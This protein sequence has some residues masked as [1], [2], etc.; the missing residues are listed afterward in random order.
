[1][2]S[3]PVHTGA[4]S[5]QLALAMAHS[6]ALRVDGVLPSAPATTTA[7]DTKIAPQPGAEPPQQ[8]A[9]S[10]LRTGVLKAQ[11]M[12]CT[13]ADAAADMSMSSAP[14]LV[15]SAAVSTQSTVDVSTSCTISVDIVGYA[16]ASVSSLSGALTRAADGS[17]LLVRPTEDARNTQVSC[18]S[19]ISQALSHD[20]DS[21]SVLAQLTVVS[22]RFLFYLCFS[23]RSSGTQTRESTSD[24]RAVHRRPVKHR[25]LED[26]SISAA[27]AAECCNQQ[28]LHRLLT[29]DAVR[30]VRQLNVE[31]SEHAL[32]EWLIAHLRS[33]GHS[34]RSSPYCLP[35]V[36]HPI[37]RRAFLKGMSTT[38]SDHH[39]GTT[40]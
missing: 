20:A 35:G 30:S 5:A 13:A 39:N 7:I 38:P 37:C 24:S 8:S 14:T 31:L 17:A 2:N 23:F 12:C 21:H 6:E 33:I 10:A 19:C 22:R 36:S 40:S 28:C 3:Q 32:T 4:L 29:F 27:L 16:A 15:A 1:M 25:L 26:A 34:S 9:G 18:Q 11:L